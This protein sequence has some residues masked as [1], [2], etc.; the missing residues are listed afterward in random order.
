MRNKYTKEFENLMISGAKTK[1]FDELYEIARRKYPI[2]KSQLRQYFS[3]RKI[4]YVGYMPT[5]AR[6]MGIVY[7]IGSEYVKN[8]GMTLVKVARDKWIYKQR[9]MYMQY[10]NCTLTNDDFIIFL[11]HDRTDFSKNNL[12]KVSRREST[13]IANQKLFSKNKELTKLGV[14]TAKLMIKVKESEEKCY[15]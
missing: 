11:N 14:Y 2:T 15:G 9:L 10:H 4:R 3:K 8:D 1:T 12:M 5:R 7:E 13:I 6:N